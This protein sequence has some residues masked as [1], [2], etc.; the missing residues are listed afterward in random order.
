MEYVMKRTLFILSFFS[1]AC[2]LSP[3][4]SASPI[5]AMPDGGM[6]FGYFYSSL[7][8]YGEWIEV[9]SGNRVWHPYRVPYQWRPYL[10]GRWVWTDDYGGYWMSDEPFGWITYHYGRWYDDDEYCW[11]WKPY[12]VWA[13][14]VYARRFIHTGSSGSQ[15]GINYECIIN[16]GVDRTVIER[17]GNVR[18]ART[19]VREIH[20]QSIERMTRSDDNQRIEIYRPSRDEMQRIP[21]RF[22][23]RRNERNLSIDMNKFEQPRREPGLQRQGQQRER[24]RERTPQIQD[25]QLQRDRQEMRRELIQRHERNLKPSPPVFREGRQQ[26]IERRREDSRIAQPRRSTQERRSGNKSNR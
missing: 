15:Y 1:A 19:E 4:S 22:D 26:R 3:K 6:H 23:G 2:V 10:V 24:V 13:P 8:P 20:G 11:V 5:P 12:D 9:E 17:R 16:R 21:G 7:A 14:E 18:F 25:R